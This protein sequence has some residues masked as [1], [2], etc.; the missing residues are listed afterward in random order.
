[1]LIDNSGDARAE[2]DDELQ[3]GP[4]EED[5]ELSEHTQKDL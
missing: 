4:A 1:M 3:A 2:G 5:P